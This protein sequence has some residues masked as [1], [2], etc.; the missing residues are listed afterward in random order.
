MGHQTLG[1]QDT[2][3]AL[4][5]FWHY[6]SKLRLYIVHKFPQ[7]MHCHTHRMQVF[8]AKGANSHCLVVTFVHFS[9]SDLA[10]NQTSCKKGGY[11]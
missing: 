2:S 3:L 1:L 7:S 5:L 10:F 6:K 8:T 9:L 4:L 11:S